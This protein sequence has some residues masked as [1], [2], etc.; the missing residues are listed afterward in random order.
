MPIELYHNDKNG[1]STRPEP[2]DLETANLREALWIDLIH[3]TDEE[4]ELVQSALNLELPTRADMREIE[5]T[6]R[7]YTEEGTRFMTALLMTR[8]DTLD[9]VESEVTFVLTGKYLVTL[10]HSEPLAFKNVRRQIRKHPISNRDG[11]FIALLEAIIDR[12]ADVLERIARNL[13][14]TSK[15]IFARDISKRK[16]TERELL[17]LVN[18]LGS[19]GDLISRHRESL[20]TLDRLVTY[21]GLEDFDENSPTYLEPRLKP[22]D[23]DIRSLSEQVNFLSTKIGFMLDATLG[24]ISIEQNAIAKIFTIAATLFLPA[25]LIASLYGMNFPWMPGLNQPWGFWIAIGLMLISA[26]LAIAL[27]RRKGWM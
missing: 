23:L 20:V 11:L 1:D 12:E 8:S 24:L 16:Q 14:D 2:G 4:R 13:D 27:F 25:T 9:P 7:L 6:S 18:T 19:T 22:I 15:A 10:R 5:T 21:A 17:H 3:P 26:I